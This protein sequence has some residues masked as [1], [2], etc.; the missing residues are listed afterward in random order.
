MLQ[1][2]G[3]NTIARLAVAIILMA[4]P[5]L[6]TAKGELT[7][8]TFTLANGMTVW[9]NEDHTQPK[10]F[11]AV[12]V[13]AGAKDCPNSG[14]AHYLEHLLFK[15]TQKIGTTDYAAEKP[16][17]DSI[18]AQYDQLAKTTDARQRA[19]IQ[20]H[21]NMLSI[22][23]ADY[24]IPNEFSNLIS[25]YGGTGLNAYTSFDETVFHNTF[26]P[27]FIRQWCE[28]NAER[29][30][31]PVFRLFQGELETVY[32]EKNMYSDNL[33]ASTAEKAQQFALDGTPYAYPIVGAT[34]S[35]K[36]PRLSE[37]MRFFKTYYVPANMGLILT[38]DI[39]PDS[40]MGI[41][42]NTFGKLA[43]S[44]STLPAR[45]KAELRDFRSTPTLK[46]KVP[47]P[48]VKIGGFA[49]QAPDECSS[50]YAAFK[51]MT[52]MLT[53]SDHTGLIDSLANSG[54][55][56]FDA[57]MGYDFKDFS[58]WGFGFVPKLPFGSRKKA[59]KLC[60]QQIDKLKRGMFAQSALDAEKLTLSRNEA[61]SLEA[62]N[63]R[64]TAMINAF[65]HGLPWEEVADRSEEIAAV[66]KADIMR[67]AKKYLNDD[68]LKI[69]KKFGHYPKERLSQPG[70]KPVKPKNA[71]AKSEYAKAMAKEP[72]AEVKP[73]LIRL[74]GGD[75]SDSAGSATAK[76]TALS[77]LV[78]LYTTRN[79]ENDVFTLRIVYRRGYGNDRRLSAMADYLDEI[80][81]E[82]H[83]K[84]RF[85]QL[86]RQQGATIDVEASASDVTLTLTGVDSRFK[87][88]V[89]LLH[90][91]I[92]QPKADKKKFKDMVKSTRIEESTFFKENQN[93]AQA[94]LAKVSKGSDSYYLNRISAKELKRMSGEE[95]VRLFKE[96]Q[97]WQTD[98][99]YCGRRDAKDVEGIVKS[100]V[101]INRVAHAW[102]PAR[103]ELRP[104]G[105][106]TVYIYDN[107]SARQTV[108]ATYQQAA[109]M[110][111]AKDRARLLLWG[112]Y[113]G[114][115][116]Q[117]VT[118]QEI[119]EYRA[120]AYSAHGSVLMPDLRMQPDSP[121]GYITL[122]GTQADKA[123]Q[124]TLLIDSLL[125]NMPLNEANVA[126]ARQSIINSI[127]NTYPSF[128]SLGTYVAS[129]CLRGYDHDPNGDIYDALTGMGMGDINQLYGQSIQRKPKAIIIVGNKKLLDIEKIRKLGKIES[130][131]KE[132]IYN[133]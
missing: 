132:N 93:I 129:L 13:R 108:I 29:L 27:Q 107:P 102:E 66:T 101:D 23:A 79:P 51:V 6:A 45:P 33:L 116:M 20:R 70:Y 41:I 124:T 26:S 72:V 43:A 67:V 68:S 88:A 105:E 65:S 71:G 16:W 18:S 34:D 77:P 9:L 130:I 64:R 37:M 114:G 78:N 48:I 96:L 60:L 127:N 38:G 131:S 85:G 55:M 115:G 120:L 5:R 83:D 109:P 75:E 133:H 49:W 125:D 89:T 28:L 92:S 58:A 73:K 112:N 61:V 4:L 90:E 32:E 46:L 104:V 52:S 22:K 17:L 10:V 2:M 91:L 82:R 36:N 106:P 119:R 97:L 98:I 76:K 54:K 42:D 121:C 128:R 56:M 99:I 118:F 81:S 110:P 95:L 47:V 12:V 94:V 15:G 62:V 35:L 44:L 59:E 122:I 1:K 84:H 69:V 63:T 87:E 50:D 39:Q 19:E 31:D 7:V 103:Q 8:K 14:I 80:G 21:I 111:T 11:G 113:F 117:S 57:G 100:C 126:P 53:N 25:L 24:A 86:L 30:R 40:I 123:T 3:I 74:G